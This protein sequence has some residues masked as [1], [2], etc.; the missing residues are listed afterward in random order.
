MTC[1]VFRQI[2]PKSKFVRWVITLMTGTGLAQALLVA[3]SPILTRLYTPEDFGVFALYSSICMVLVIFATGKYE[4]AIIVPKYDNE[5]INL[6]TVT[7]GLS[8]LVSATLLGF[9]LIW[10][11]RIIILL[12]HPEV[13]PWL[14]LVPLTTLIL[15]CHHALNFWTNRRVRYKSMAASRVMQSGVSV[16]MQLAAGVSK[17]GF[18]GL[19]MGQMAGQ[20]ISTLFLAKSLSLED[21]RLFRRVSIKRMSCVAR[22]HIGYPKYMV[23]GQIM[24][25]GSNELPLLL[26]TVFFG[27]GVA[28][29]YSLAKRVIEAPLSLVAAAVGD[30]YRQKA[31]AQYASQGECLNLFLASSKWLLMFALLTVLP[32]IL[33]G[34]SLFSFV[35]G[36]NWR[37][38]GEIAS[39][40]AILAFF[41]TV[42]SPLSTTLLLVGWLH[43]D[44]LWQFVRIILAGLAFYGGY[45]LTGE[46][47]SS[48]KIYI[49]LISVL[50]IL[51]SF[52]QYKA[53][54]GKKINEKVRDIHEN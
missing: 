3:F 4:L 49:L 50:Y 7:A 31:A 38:A 2:L 5:A 9:V 27:V 1:G 28:G 37:V 41:Q 13:G 14:Y 53:A 25:V 23:P 11:A 36:E 47:M 33:F 24:S 34:P 19:I 48:I 45:K 12:G 18:P 6:V 16:S 32:V 15:G 44:F 40:L 10:G 26:L 21:R 8:L 20:L 46:Y 35:F 51:Y 30:V 52:F 22:K 17:L 54:Q 43:I 42:S 39:L 29:F